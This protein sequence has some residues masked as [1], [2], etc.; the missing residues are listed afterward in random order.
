MAGRSGSSF[1]KRQKEM[2]RAE[3]QREKFARRIA[4]KEAP[5]TDE[6]GESTTHENAEQPEAASSL[7]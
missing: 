2:E 4:K 1:Q 5:S 6:T 7:A 3:K